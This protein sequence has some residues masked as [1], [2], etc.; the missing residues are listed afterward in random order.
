MK[1][2]I[3]GVGA[4]GI[5]AAKTIRQH[6]ELDEIVMIST[7]EVV[8]SRCMLHKYIGGERT[9]SELSFVHPQF[10]C[11]NKI[12]W[13]YGAPVTQVDSDKKHVFFGKGAEAYDKLLIATGSQSAFPPING[14]HEARDVYGLR[15]LSDA[16][17]IRK[18]AAEAKHIVIIGAGLVGLDAAYGLTELG[19]KPVIIEASESIL[20]ANLDAHAATV[21][22]KNFE[23]SGCRF[24]LGTKVREVVRKADESVGV[25]VLD[26]EERLP[27]DLLIVA[28]GISPAVGFLI[29]S[30]IAC[31]HGVV[32]DRYLAANADGVYA[33][34]DV[35]GLSSSWPSAIEQ[36]EVA[37]LNMCGVPTVYDEVISLKNTV[38]FF[39]VASLSVG[40]FMPNDGDEVNIREDRGRYQKVIIRDGVPVGV[41]LQGDISRSGFWQY[42]I[43]NKV[44]IASIPKSV[45]KISF[46]DS[47]GM[48]KNGE[49]MWV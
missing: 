40:Q 20:S 22:Q 47:Y 18:K 6:R 36:G 43:E 48:D 46:A 12:R 32:V 29:N 27:C 15:D 21:Y 37:A 11:D 16:K 23:G 31:D 38:N 19:K 14:L 8:Y 33:A 42:L 13:I 41:I 9:V 4:A 49:Y 34:G 28:A 45:W 7:D 3:I 2:V 30:E 25:V 10:F 17:A 1:H 39:G 26:N 5:S 44:S 24:R 35:T